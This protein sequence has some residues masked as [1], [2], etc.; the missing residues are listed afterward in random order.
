MLRVLLVSHWHVVLVC[1]Y[2]QRTADPRSFS[3][4]ARTPENAIVAACTA[5]Q[6]RGMLVFPSRDT[7]V[8]QRNAA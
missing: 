6:A 3:V 4:Q 2:P 5:A 1:G 8:R 7:H